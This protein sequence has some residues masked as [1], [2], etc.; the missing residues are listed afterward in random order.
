MNI[1]LFTETYL[2]YINGVVTHVKS[3]KEGL[4]QLGHQVLVV[5]ADPH[6]RHHYVSDGILHC[7]GI[8]NKRIYEYGV[9]AP[10]APHRL[11]LLKEFHPDIIHIH[12]EFGVG[13]SGIRYAKE[14]EIPLV[15][16][17]HTMYEDYLYYIFPNKMIP[18]AKRLMERYARYIANRSSTLFGPSLKVE[19]FFRECDVVKDV[20]IMENPVELE[21]FDKTKVDHEKSA[22]LKASLKLTDEDFILTFCGRLGKEKNVDTLLS[23]WKEGIG[24]EKHLKLL[25]LGDGPVKEELEQQAKELGVSDTVIF[26]GRVE[27]PQ[28]PLYYDFCDLY[29]TASLSDTNSISMKEGLAMCLPV[30]SLTDSLNEG[31]IVDGF[32][33]FNYNNAAELFE[34]IA[35]YRAMDAGEKEALRGSARGSVLEASCVALAKTVLPIYEQLIAENQSK[36]ADASFTE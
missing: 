11:K 8:T 20:H 33:G 29:V 19:E 4:E 22:A 34:R 13:L 3:L 21:M 7:P 28:L 26:A 1:A 16:T 24:E 9:A 2:P 15:Y 36:K 30:L 12:N 10:I 14:L 35:F 32:N 25:I 27:H 18:L 5:C 17:L 31:Q 6:A 23:F